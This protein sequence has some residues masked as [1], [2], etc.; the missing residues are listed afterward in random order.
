MRVRTCM[1]SCRRIHSSPY[2]ARLLHRRVKVGIADSYGVAIRPLDASRFAVDGRLPSKS[3]APK[4]R[5]DSAI[6]SGNTSSGERA[7]VDTKM[8]SANGKESNRAALD[9]VSSCR[10][11][12][13]KSD[14]CTSALDRAPGRM[15]V[16][17]PPRPVAYGVPHT[18]D[19][20]RASTT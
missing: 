3:A 10:P 16:F 20:G 7:S 19:F 12:V 9:A 11:M 4:V 14:G 17:S 5:P 15:G 2:I 1:A 13:T 18:C 8:V 6:L